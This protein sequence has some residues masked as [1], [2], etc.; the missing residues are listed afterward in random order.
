MC[1]ITNISIKKNSNNQSQ[2]KIL[3]YFIDFFDPE[4]CNRLL[5][6]SLTRAFEVSISTIKLK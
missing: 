5:N 2:G 4:Q 3:I 1:N 6:W